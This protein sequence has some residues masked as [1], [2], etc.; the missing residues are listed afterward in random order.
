MGNLF[1]RSGCRML[2]EGEEE[3]DVVKGKLRGRM[4]RVPHCARRFAE[5]FPIQIGL[6]ILK[7]PSISQ[8]HLNTT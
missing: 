7:S 6:L 1:I 3:V 4:K 8:T 2:T 5:L